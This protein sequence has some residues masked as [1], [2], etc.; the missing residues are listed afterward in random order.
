M[1]KNSVFVHEK[2]ICE[3]KDV[4]EG[5]RIWG[6][7]HVMPEARIGKFCTLGEH[8]FVENKVWIGDGCTIKN[9]VAIWESVTLEDDVFIGPFAVFT[10]DLKPRA[11]LKRRNSSFLH[12]VIKRGATIGANATIRCGVTIGEFAMI[13]A[14]SMVT[15]DVA[16]HTLVVGNP[17]KTLSKVCFCGER[18]T[19]SDLC[20]LCDLKLSENSIEKTIIRVQE[21]KSE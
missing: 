5:T 19:A 3:T 12:T 17:A 2:A 4:G 7:S 8:V 10:N 15:K 9:G 20:K 11:F 13:G 14:G 6:F 1:A 21:R 18:L 16:P